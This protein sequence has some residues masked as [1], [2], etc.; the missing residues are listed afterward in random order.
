[1]RTRPIGNST[2]LACAIHFGFWAAA[3]L[4]QSPEAIKLANEPALSPDG[5]T[6]VFAWHGDLWKVDAKGGNATPLT[7]HPAKDREPKFS[8]DGKH[9]AFVSDREGTPQIFVMAA[10][11]GPARQI[12]FHT[13]GSALA[14]WFPDG[15][16][17][18]TSAAR[19][20]YWRKPERFFKV[21]VETRAAETLL[22]D[23]YGTQGKLSPDGRQLLFVREGTQ[24]WRKGYTGS[25][26]PRIWHYDLEARTFKKLIDTPAGA[27]SPIW[28]ADGKGFYYVGLHRG[29]MNLRR[30]NL[31]GSDDKPLTSFDDDL[32]VQPSLA[33]DGK[34]IVFR[35]L[36]DLY[37]LDLAKPDATPEKIEIRQTADAIASAVERRALTSAT[38]AA[39]TD[40]GL[41]TSFI[42][43]GDVWVMDTELTE[44][45]RVTATPEEERSVVFAPDGKSLVFV[46][47][48]GGQIDLWRARRADESKAWWENEKFTL[49]RITNDAESE[50]DPRFSPAGGKLAFIKGLGQLWIAEAD[51]SAP[52]KLMESWNAPE[53][54]WSPDG[55]WIVY[56]VSDDD[57]NSDIWIRPIDGSKPP[58]NISRHPDND[59]NPVWSPDGRTIAFTGRRMAEESDIY[60]VHLRKEDDD[61]SARDRKLQKAREKMKAARKKDAAKPASE[62]AK[63]SADADADKDKP[64]EKKDEP[65][66]DEPGKK[67]VEV[68]IDFEG[69]P[70]R[71]RR[72][73]IPNTT[74]SGLFW[75]ADS[76]KL[77]FS[78][79]IDGQRGTHTIEPPEN[80]KPTKLT[81]T[82]GTGA[83]W[84]ETGNQIVWLANGAPGSLTAGGKESSYRVRALQEVKRSERFRAGFD[85]A[86]RTMRD[87]WYDERLGN[88]N[89][90][91]IRRKYADAAASAPDLDTLATVIQLMLGELNGSHLGFFP[92]VASRPDP[93]ADDP[94]AG[95]PSWRPE[96]AYFGVRFD[97][98]H[99]GPGLKIR[100]V[101]KDSPAD[102]AGSRLSA[103][104]TILAID[105]RPVD[106]SM[107]LTEVLNGPLD[108][109]IRLKV[110]P[111]KGDPRTVM[112]RPISVRSAGRLLY[113]HWIDKNRAIV[114][115]L[116][117]GTLGY[118]HI[119]AMDETSFRQFEQDLYDAG[120]GKEGLVIDVRENGGGSTADLLL[121]SL[122]QPVHAFTVPRGGSTPGYPHDRMVFATWRKPIIVLCN[123]N[124]FSN[125]EIF[126]HAIKTLKR[127][128]LVG[129]PT[130]GGVIST[131]G[132]AITDIGFLRLPFRG[133]YLRDTGE[134]MELNG[135]VP[136]V[137]IWPAPGDMPAGKDEQLMKA[138]ELLNADVAAEKAKPKP[139]LRKATER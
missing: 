44:P 73:T 102:K 5:K 81:A 128:K 9:I 108:R 104:E 85:Q 7:R 93:N 92:G 36:F 98:S 80:L 47:E 56:A 107:D 20:H 105:D 76:K 89:W 53:F 12:T 115:K 118:L 22:F 126:S 87:R 132:T 125:A 127:G 77:A 131:G 39:F 58:F 50:S 75:S 130:A 18:L 120:A 28:T 60:Y 103:G 71:L 49:D 30:R 25:Q 86:W 21:S 62:P 10:E 24:W 17:L 26:A 15:K 23:D 79:T 59:S 33:R 82:T 138:V 67:P 123:Q 91:A 109:E 37:R 84:L 35:H 41:E 121:T 32:V 97:N 57:F 112:I 68:V 122:T 110:A 2:V 88:R 19:D 106:P 114:D 95:G 65:K 13:G 69:L 43:G 113:Q 31:D 27:Y 99:K 101:L 124:S 117:G 48:T 74:E 11:G 40:D 34:S 70:Q 119:R 96:T 66:K 8:P 29:T 83:R 137:T 3:V 52:K 100:D 51:G 78:A 4:A 46:S 94:A 129:V 45:R 134:D 133:W 38:Q 135:A 1:M 42:A 90:D 55:K 14:D 61:Q 6:I 136:D 116:S 16:F 139:K 72:V 111:E 64:E 63:K 54:D